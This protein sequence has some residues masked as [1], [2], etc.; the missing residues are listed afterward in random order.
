MK[1]LL[2]FQ[3]TIFVYIFSFAQ[4]GKQPVKV[5]DMLK[6]KPLGSLSLTDD[7]SKAAFTVLSIEPDG[8]K[9]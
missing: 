9:D 3:V 4:N 7:G 8:S 6:I 2:L 5:T 1:K